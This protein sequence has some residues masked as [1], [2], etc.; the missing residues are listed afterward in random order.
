[1]KKIKSILL[2]AEGATVYGE[3]DSP[4]GILTIIGSPQ[5]LHA[6]LWDTCVAS[7]EWQEI[8]SSLQKSD[9]ETIIAQ[10]KKQLTEYFEGKRKTFD[11]P[12]KLNGTNF[13]MQAWNQL[14]AIPYGT[15]ISYAEQ[16]EKIANKNKARAV[17]TA[18]GLNPISIVIPCH[19]VIG[20]NGCLGGFGGGI[21]KKAYLLQLEQ[22]AEKSCR[23]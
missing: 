9:S 2:A 6:I 21:E 7:L 1:M 22:A 11:L 15:T 20:S 3:M 18:N 12:L 13:Q 8:L 10:T 19:R 14:L 5:G 16:A 4:V 23:R 17:G